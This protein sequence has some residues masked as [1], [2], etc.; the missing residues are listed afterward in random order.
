M[1]KDGGVI[2]I[3][4]FDIPSFFTW[5]SVGENWVVYREGVYWILGGKYERLEDNPI[6][7]LGIGDGKIQS[8]TVITPSGE[9]LA[10][11]EWVA[12]EWTQDPSSLMAGEG[13]L[14]IPDDFNREELGAPWI[15]ESDAYTPPATDE[16]TIVNGRASHPGNKYYAVSVYDDPIPGKNLIVAAFQLYGLSGATD[17]PGALHGSLY[18]DMTPQKYYT[19]PDDSG[20]GGIWFESHPDWSNANRIDIFGFPIGGANWGQAEYL[21]TPFYEGE[22]WAVSYD[23]TDWS[24]WRGPEYGDWTLV[25]SHPDTYTGLDHD[26]YARVWLLDDRPETG[27]AQTPSFDNFV[28][29]N[30][31]T[32]LQNVFNVNTG[33]GLE[34]DSDAVRIAASAA[35]DGLQG[36]GGTALSV[37]DDVLRDADLPLGAGDLPSTIAY[38]DE[39]NTFSLAQTFDLAGEAIKLSSTSGYIGL[40]DNAVGQATYLSSNVGLQVFGDTATSYAAMTSKWDDG[41]YRFTRLVDGKMEWGNGTDALDTN[42]YRNAANELKTDDDL[43]VLGGLTVNSTVT[44]GSHLG[45]GVNSAFWVKGNSFLDAG[46]SGKRALILKRRSGQ[47]ANLMDIIS[48]SGTAHVLTGFD[49]DGK[50][51][52]ADGAGGAA[53]TNLYRSD[54]DTLKTDDKFIASGG[55]D[56][57]DNTITNVADP[58]NDDDAATKGWVVSQA[59][60]TYTAG[61]GLTESP[62]NT[63]NVNPGDGIQLVTDEVRVTDDVLRD[64]DISVSVAAVDTKGDL[65]ATVAY[66]D[67]AN[68]FTVGTQEVFTT[69]GW[70]GFRATTDND[71]SYPS[72]YTYRKRTTGDVTQSGDSLGT[73]AMR[74]HDGADYFSQDAVRLGGYASETHDATHHGAA[75]HLYTTANAA[76]SPSLRLTIDQDGSANFQA[77]TLTNIADPTDDAHVGDRAYND[78]RYALLNAANTFTL[79]QTISHAD[80]LNLSSASGELTFSTDTKIIRKAAGQMW[81]GTDAET[82]PV[83][84]EDGLIRMKDTADSGR[85]LELQATKVSVGKIN[86]DAYDADNTG[87]FNVRTRNDGDTVL[88]IFGAGSEN[89]R[90]QLQDEVTAGGTMRFYEAGTETMRLDTDGTIKWGSTQDTSLYRSAASTLTFDANTAYFG[91]GVGDG[92]V[93]VRGPATGGVSTTAKHSFILGGVTKMSIFAY[94]SAAEAYSSYCDFDN[95]FY[96]RSIDDSYAN[97]FRIGTAGNASYRNLDLQGNTLYNLADPTDGGHVGDRDYN[98]GRYALSTGNYAILDAANDFTTSPQTISHAG[99]K[100]TLALSSTGTDTGITFGGDTNLYRSSADTLKTDDEFQAETGRFGSSSANRGN[101]TVGSLGAGDPR[102]SLSVYG[103]TPD[104]GTDTVALYSYAQHGLDTGTTS[105]AYAIVGVS[106]RAQIL[107]TAK[108]E[109]GQMV[110]Q[111]RGVQ[112]QVDHLSTAVAL[113]YAQG[114]YSAFS[115]QTSTT[116]TEARHFEAYDSAQSGTIGTQYGLYLNDLDAATTNYGI[117]FAG[118]SGLA[119][120]GIWW[121]GDT[122]LYRSAANTLKTDDA[123]VVDASGLTALNLSNT[124]LNTGITI[125][126]DVNIYRAI[127]N[128]W[129][130][131]DNLQ[132]AGKLIVNGDPDTGEYVGNRDYNDARYEALGGGG[133]T[134]ASLAVLGFS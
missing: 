71:S 2:Q 114:F 82:N 124:T 57:G 30:S 73:Y 1:L 77:N 60:V 22:W 8:D 24:V 5:P 100:D 67:E 134:F 131:D 102:A 119:R 127:A 123:F 115:T 58:V 27:Q 3:A 105:T 113:P 42:L 35:G 84:I 79:G 74:G 59:G 23:G 37:T 76:T 69:S 128:W 109:A 110:T 80:G 15:P 122:N 68:V 50:L 87:L 38:E 116:I 83:R 111:V 93:L 46:T 75:F 65:P 125:G 48:E 21:T 29:S 10:T 99:G 25:V 108:D 126:G 85:S 52:F 66:K 98:D 91:L 28:L 17:E 18:L 101:M 132:V 33:T 14:E 78:T 51:V 61:D 121:N 12:Q 43:N 106:G 39:E 11:K 54:D 92:H 26:W 70:N 96:F 94:K 34:I 63:F 97:D 36:G 112:A 95:N 117:Y 103:S 45:T 9:T 89:D 13:L 64:A 133:A 55:L 120:Q 107:A 86:Q 47:T 49:K 72:F 20:Y 129:K 90:I 41:E 56:S 32:T 7:N 130:T 88:F 6:E 62:D 81:L 44:Q 53:D 31:L 40:G 118:T 104:G 4:V 16:L 19:P